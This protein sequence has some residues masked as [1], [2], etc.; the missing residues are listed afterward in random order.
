MCMD[1]AS[2]IYIGVLH[3]MYYYC[4]LCN[5]NVIYIYIYIYIYEA[6]CNKTFR[7]KWNKFEWMNLQK[8]DKR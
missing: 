6:L 1:E 8:L 7:G 5:N 4:Y 3:I 2:F